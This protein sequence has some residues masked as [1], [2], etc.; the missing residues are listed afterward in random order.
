M[1]LILLAAA[2]F[3]AV[4]SQA[5]AK[6]IVLKLS[7]P[8]MAGSFFDKNLHVPFVKA[9]ESRNCG[10]VKIQYFPSGQIASFPDS[11][12]AVASGRADI[13]HFVPDHSRG[14]FPLTTIVDVPFLFPNQIMATVIVNELLDKVLFKEFPEVKVFCLWMTPAHG[15]QTAQDKPV[16]RL[17]E[18]NG[19]KIRTLGG[20]STPLL[21][22]LGA[23]PTPV[24]VAETYTA[25]E[26][27]VIDGALFNMVAGNIFKLNELK[28]NVTNVGLFAQA[29]VVGFNRKVWD[30]LPPDIQNTFMGTGYEYAAKTGSVY[31]DMDVFARNEYKKAGSKIFELPPEEV[32][33]WQKA[34]EPTVKANLDEMEKK[35]LPAYEV[36]NE[37]VKICEKY[38]VEVPYKF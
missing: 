2:F 7:N 11:Y 9:L 4:C 37:F 14:R 5:A 12:E 17:E 35:G 21:K 36:W 3:L 29:W 28:L 10:K 26:R 16:Q 33:R 23:T 24:A 8:S 15:I 19:L 1:F 27:G 30:S 32:A 38:E 13:A 20:L 22:A 31:R 18:L 6:P 34:V 25:L